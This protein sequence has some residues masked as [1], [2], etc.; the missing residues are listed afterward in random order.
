MKRKLESDD[1][2]DTEINCSY[3]DR[4]RDQLLEQD[5]FVRVIKRELCF[6]IL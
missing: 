1:E 5:E 2:L 3:A 6:T 4:F